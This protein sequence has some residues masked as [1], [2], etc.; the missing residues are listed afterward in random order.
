MT[1]LLQA[2]LSAHSYNIATQN[3]PPHVLTFLKEG[4]TKLTSR[5]LQNSFPLL[6]VQKEGGGGGTSE[7]RRAGHIIMLASKLGTKPQYPDC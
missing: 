6:Y 2:G 1:A 4:C 3:A 7:A 5:H